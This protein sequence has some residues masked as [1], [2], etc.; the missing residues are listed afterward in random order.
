MATASPMCPTPFPAS[1][2][3]SRWPMCSTR[4]PSVEGL[5]LLQHGIFTVGDT[6]RA[7]LWPHD[8]IR[9]HGGRAAEPSA[10]DRWRRPS[11]PRKIAALPEIAPILRGAVA[12]REERPGRHR[13][14]ADPGFP[15]Q[16]RDPELCEWRGAVA[17]QP[18]RRGDARP[19]HPHQELAA[20]RARAGS[21]QAGRLGGRGATRRWRP[22]SRAITRYFARNNEKSPV[23][24][25]GTRSAAARDPGAGRGHVRDR[26]HA[27][28]M[29][30]SPPTSPRT[31]S[32]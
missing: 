19:H 26:R 3:P 32:R 2:W 27:P 25:E 11:C 20:D 14:A 12:H 5:V 10:Q 22:L 31:P 6:A 15:H 17:L 4:I 21:R 24:E 23:E 16:R 13:Q 29:P 9:H 7:G 8:R 28:R 1:P 18:G 30:P